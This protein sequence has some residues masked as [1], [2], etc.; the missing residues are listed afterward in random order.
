MSEDFFAATDI[1]DALVLGYGETSELR[2]TITEFVD[3]QNV[4]AS[5][6]KD[7][8]DQFQASATTEWAMARDTFAGL[9]HAEGLEVMVLNDAVVEGPGGRRGDRRSSG[10]KP[11]TEGQRAQTDEN[12][13]PRQNGLRHGGILQK[14]A[15]AQSGRI[16]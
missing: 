4:S 14:P 9:S 2:L 12:G 11:G 3:A 10:R 16:T 7:V 5:P 13:A 8:E 1:G 15:A 6:N